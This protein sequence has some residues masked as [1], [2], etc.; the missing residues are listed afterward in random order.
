MWEELEEKFEHHSPSKK[1][2]DPAKGK[3]KEVTW[4]DATPSALSKGEESAKTN[5]ARL[6]KFI[7]RLIENFSK[8]L[9]MTDKEGNKLL[10]SVSVLQNCI[11]TLSD[12]LRYRFLNSSTY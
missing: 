4:L 7:E 8:N 5:S 6:C 2:D 10:L 1:V 12:A 9:R 11:V 3:K